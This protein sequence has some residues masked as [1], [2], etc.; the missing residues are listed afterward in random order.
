MAIGIAIGV[1]IV[2]L[3][4]SAM[5][6]GS[7]VAF[8][9][10]DSQDKNLLK[11]ENSPAARR[12]LALTDVTEYKYLLATILVLNNVFNVA[13]VI[14]SYFIFSSLFDFSDH[15]ALG[16]V[17]NVIGVTSFLLLFG[18]VMPKVYANQNNLVMARRMAGPLHSCNVVLKKTGI[19]KV[20][21]NATDFIENR[22]GKLKSR[23]VDVE[24]INNAIDLT[25]GPKSKEQ[26][27]ILKTENRWE[28]KPINYETPTH[29]H[30]NTS[31]VFSCDWR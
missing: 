24:E 17:V 25:V 31:S 28:E 30:L 23:G 29:H 15:P 19:S 5:I 22:I 1:V 27:K 9:S 20:L 10:I 18:E 4:A 14:V 7:E 16:F 2:L 26:M 3:A 6:S 13:I 12:I 11:E 21:A 8:F